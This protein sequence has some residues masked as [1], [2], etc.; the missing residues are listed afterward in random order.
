MHLTDAARGV[1]DASL[2]PAFLAMGEARMGARGVQLATLL[3][4]LLSEVQRNT[5]IPSFGLCAT[6]R[7]HEEVNG[8]PFC[9]LTQQQLAPNDAELICREHQLAISA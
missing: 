5:D 2:R 3:S 8:L 1:L 6:C 4:E 7:F 9:G